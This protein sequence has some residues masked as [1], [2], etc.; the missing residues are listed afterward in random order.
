LPAKRRGKSD[1]DIDRNARDWKDLILCNK[2]E[3]RHMTIND[4]L[5]LPSKIRVV[6]AR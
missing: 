5:V 4:Y 1:V 6:A 3:F 2:I